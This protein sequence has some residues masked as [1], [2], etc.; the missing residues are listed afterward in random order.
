MPDQSI[1][2]SSI[3]DD[4]AVTADVARGSDEATIRNAVSSAVVEEL[5]AGGIGWA[6]AQTGS[7]GTIR[8]V[9][10]RRSGSALCRSFVASRE[11]FDGVYL[12]RGSACLGTAGIWTMKSFERIE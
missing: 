8:D 2:T 9:A 7:R 3:P 1:V 4:P 11:S 5:E 12:Y 10:E 6:N